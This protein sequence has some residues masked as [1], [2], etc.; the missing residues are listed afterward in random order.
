MGQSGK[1]TKRRRDE[2]AIRQRVRKTK[3]ETEILGNKEHV[4]TRE[5]EV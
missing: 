1:E 4:N 2:L 5:R 3:I